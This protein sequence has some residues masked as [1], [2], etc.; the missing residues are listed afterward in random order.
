MPNHNT[1]VAVYNT[2]QDAQSAVDELRLS[3][4]DMKKLSIIG[5]EVQTEQDVIGYYSSGDRTIYWGKQGAFWGALGGLLL[6]AAFFLVPGVGAV[7]IAGPLAAYIASAVEGAVVVGGLSAIGAG[8]FSLGIP[9]N[10]ILKYEEALKAD[11]FILV[12]QGTR[13][14][15]QHAREI[16]RMTNADQ[17]GVYVQD[18]PETISVGGTTS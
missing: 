6:G 12:A 4:F 17:I 13:D 1:I 18:A 11:K 5:R 8:L 2:D 15:V 9:K 10:S 3:G 14:G 7:L 16:V